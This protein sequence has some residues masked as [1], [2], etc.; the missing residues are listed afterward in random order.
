[1]Q[2]PIST[3]YARTHARACIPDHCSPAFHEHACM[4]ITLFGSGCISLSIGRH[5]NDG[6]DEVGRG[7]H[8][9]DRPHDS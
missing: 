6:R 1:M 2:R 8:G 9:K 3:T 7:Y 4:H 5:T